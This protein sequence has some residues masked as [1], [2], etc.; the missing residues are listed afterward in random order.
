MLTVKL[1]QSNKWWLGTQSQLAFFEIVHEIP[2][3]N[4]EFLHVFHLR[5]ST[6]LTVGK[7]WG[8]Q[9]VQLL[10]KDIDMLA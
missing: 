5:Q 8:I 10:Q 6:C 9:G 1:V 4:P 3:S 7:W 2:D